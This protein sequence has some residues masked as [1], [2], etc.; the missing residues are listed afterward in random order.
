MTEHN[1]AHCDWRDEIKTSSTEK[2]ATDMTALSRSCAEGPGETSRIRQHPPPG[3]E[4][5]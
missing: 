5:A 1:L 2:Q 4:N 3:G